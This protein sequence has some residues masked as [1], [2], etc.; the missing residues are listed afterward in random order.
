MSFHK[1][2]SNESVERYKARLVTKEFYQVTGVNYFKT[3]S[4]W[5]NL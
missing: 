5:L 1:Q 3:F 4:Q 2:K